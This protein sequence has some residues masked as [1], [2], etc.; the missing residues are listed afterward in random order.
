MSH[1]KLLKLKFIYD[2][3][4]HNSLHDLC[5]YYRVKL[6]L[7]KRVFRKNT[8]PIQSYILLHHLSLRQ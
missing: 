8:M 7:I 3:R 6:Y 5:S 4:A 1:K 2:L